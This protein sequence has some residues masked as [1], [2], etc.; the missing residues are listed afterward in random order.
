MA[1]LVCSLATARTTPVKDFEP[2]SCGFHLMLMAFLT[3]MGSQLLSVL[4]V[5]L[6]IYNRLSPPSNTYS[7]P[8]HVY[9]CCCGNSSILPMILVNL[10]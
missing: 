8:A 3:G 7:F 5:A 6:D 9:G 10:P 4:S 1:C 2:G